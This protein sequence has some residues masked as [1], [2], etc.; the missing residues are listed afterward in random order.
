MSTYLQINI[1]R[2]YQYI[3]FIYI[4]GTPIYSHS[5]ICILLLL[6]DLH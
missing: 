1:D 4:V 6:F 5:L 3:Y 2:L